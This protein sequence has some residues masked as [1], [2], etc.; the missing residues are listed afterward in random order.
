[1]KQL[2]FLLS[3]LLL[4]SACQKE[5]T[6]NTNTNTPNNQPIVLVNATIIGQIIDTNNDPISDVTIGLNGQ[7]VQTDEFGSFHFEKGMINA[8]GTYISASKAG[9]FLGSRRFYPM[10]NET[11][12]I[13]IKLIESELVGTISSTVG[14]KLSHDKVVIDFP[15]GAYTLNNG[16]TYDGEVNVFATYMD[17]TQEETFDQMPGDLTAIN[18]DGD[19]VGLTTYGMIGVEL[20]TQSGEEINLPDGQ[21]AEI[22]MEV[23]QSLLSEAP[24]SIPLW[25][26]NE[27]SGIWEEEGEAQLIGNEYI[28]SVSHFSF[29]NCDYPW[30]LVNIQGFVHINGIGYPGTKLRIENVST[31][32]FGYSVTGTRGIYSGKVPKDAALRLDVLDECGLVMH[33]ENIEPSS[34]D[35]Y[36]DIIEVIATTGYSSV[37]GSITNCTGATINEAA[38]NISVG[39]LS[40]LVP[41]DADQSFEVL[42]PDCLA[43]S[44]GTAVGIDFTNSLASAPQYFTLQEEVDLGIIVACDEFEEPITYV[45]YEGIPWSLSN[46]DSSIIHTY[47]VVE[48]PE[49]DRIEYIIL[50][51]NNP[52]FYVFECIFE[53][54]PG[55]SEINY[56]AN[57]SVSGFSATGTCSVHEGTNATGEPFTRFVSL[58]SEITV[59]DASLFPDGCDELFFDV[60]IIK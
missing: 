15:S 35:I 47:N 51:W 43:E 44:N 7:T 18:A 12:T 27:T 39:S 3:V 53:Y 5:T 8:N 34:E 4:F 38:V 14:G 41:V 37:S 52:S 24:T 33:S 60:H 50:D 6:N 48:F 49:F 17:P 30:E 32:G 19:L 20:T 57:V 59:T 31:N 16:S 58:N 9:Y 45:N 25:H 36:T 13:K 21:T 22:K 2:Y 54:Y 23:P 1:M 11:S 42:I 56:I 29:W 46:I 10:D 55:Q 26:F 28:G 40:T